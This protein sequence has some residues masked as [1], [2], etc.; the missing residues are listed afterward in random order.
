[1]A[2][3]SKHLKSETFQLWI[4]LQNNPLLA[5]I[6]SVRDFFTWIIYPDPQCLSLMFLNVR[7]R[8]NFS[9][10]YLPRAQEFTTLYFHVVPSVCLMIFLLSFRFNGWSLFV[11]I[12]A[13][14]ECFQERP[15]NMGLHSATNGYVKISI[16]A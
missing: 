15:W 13:Q 6:F 4:L 5:R 9:R 2:E 10:Q 14:I 16:S 8:R 1:M 7:P 11:S 12:G 3:K